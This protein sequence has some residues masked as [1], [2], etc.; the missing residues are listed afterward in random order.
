MDDPMIR[1]MSGL[2]RSTFQ[3]EDRGRRREEE[4]DKKR[5]G[6]EKFYYGS[7]YKFFK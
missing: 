2:S 6:K 4:T 7:V 3:R 5:L 1:N